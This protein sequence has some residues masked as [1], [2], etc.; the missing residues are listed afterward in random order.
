MNQMLVEMW[1]VEAILMTLMVSSAILMVSSEHEQ[2]IRQW[3][4]HD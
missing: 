2:V 1:M 3:R 4:R